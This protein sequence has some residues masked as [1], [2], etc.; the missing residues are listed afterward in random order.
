MWPIS[1]PITVIK[2]ATYTG[3]MCLNHVH[4]VWHEYNTA[5]IAAFILIGY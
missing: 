1:R 2:Y 4:S 3:L 5:I